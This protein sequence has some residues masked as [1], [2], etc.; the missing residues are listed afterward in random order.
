MY[1]DA[2]A[3]VGSK[4]SDNYNLLFMSLPQLLELVKD[5]QPTSEIKDLTDSEGREFSRN[6]VRERNFGL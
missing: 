1:Y 6:V 4:Q 5:G 2:L 3:Q